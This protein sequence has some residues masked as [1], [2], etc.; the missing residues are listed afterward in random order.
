MSTRLTVTSGPRTPKCCRSHSAY[1][2]S[3]STINKRARMRE[4]SC[5][6]LDGEANAQLHA[7]H[8]RVPVAQHRSVAPFSHGRDRGAI[9]NILRLRA[10]HGDTVN[11]A[12][13]L[14]VKCEIDP[15]AVSY[16]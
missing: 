7:S 3:R 2:R 12:V 15:A 14:H 10:Q 5:Q 13:R 6:L 16:T 9:E 8:D 4:H 11:G 1:C